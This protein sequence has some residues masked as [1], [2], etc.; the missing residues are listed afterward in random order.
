MKSKLLCLAIVACALSAAIL[1]PTC[2][3]QEPASAGWDENVY[4]AYLTDAQ[5]GTELMSKRADDRHPIASM[6][7]IMTANLVM[8]E[9]DAGRLGLD[10]MVTVSQT[11]AGMGG[12]QMFLDAGESYSVS[13]L[14]KGVIVASANDASVALAE[15]I[16]GSHEAFVAHMNARAKEY[17][18]ENT[19]FC[20]ATGLPSE[21][22]QY[23]T[24]RDVNCMTRKLMQHE[25][26]FRYAQIPMEDYTH[27]SGRVTQLVNTNKLLRGYQGCKGGKTGFTDAA[28][29]CLSACAERNGLS[30]VATVIGAPDSKTRFR[31]VSKLWDYAF[32]H[33]E[34]KLVLKQDQPCDYTVPVSK[35]ACKQMPI[36]PEHDLRILMPKGAEAVEP[37]Y[38]IPERISAP[39]KRGDVIGKAVVRYDG[40]TYTVN[41]IACQ[42]AP[43]YTWW[44]SLKNIVSQW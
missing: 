13:D 24:A 16:D 30:A 6:V 20:N 1:L 27:P 15:Q 21:E 2:M 5:M 28:G 26:Y 19:L 33:Y 9:I 34:N 44:E 8:E 23:S 4:S 40:Q 22:E 43:K 36:A 41:L 3:A 10:T 38:Q 12:S 32:A 37:E 7:K 35:S 25:L 14:L 17:G 29:F 11:A 39:V 18:M 31:A 42:D